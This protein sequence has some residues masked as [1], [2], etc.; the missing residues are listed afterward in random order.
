MEKGPAMNDQ[1]S[2]ERERKTV[3][4]CGDE[5]TGRRCILARGHDGK[6][7]CQTATNVHTWTDR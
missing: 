7:E 2:E 3:E 4:L 6:H 1:C 5:R